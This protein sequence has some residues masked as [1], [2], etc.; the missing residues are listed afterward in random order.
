MNRIL[1]MAP[2][3]FEKY[4]FAWHLLFTFNVLIE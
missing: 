2:G 4:Y 1:Q 3:K